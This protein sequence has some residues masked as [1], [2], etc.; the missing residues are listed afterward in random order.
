MKYFGLFCI[1]T[2][3]TLGYTQPPDTLWTRTYGGTGNDVG[4]SIKQT[5]D[6][7]YIIAGYTESFGAGQQD[8]WLLKTDGSGNTVWTKTYGGAYDDWAT[9]VQQTIDGGYVIAATTASFPY[10]VGG[11]M[12][13]MKTDPQGDTIWTEIYNWCDQAW[14][15]QQTSDS[16]YIVSGRRGFYAWDDGYVVI[17]KTDANGDTSWCKFYFR[18]AMA[19]TGSCVHETFDGNFVATAAMYTWNGTGFSFL[20]KTNS[21]GDSLWCNEYW[22]PMGYGYTSCL[23]S[24]TQTADSGY[25]TCGAKG[26][27]TLGLWIVR[28]TAQGDSIW[29]REYE[30]SLSGRFGNSVQI[31]ND[32]CF[33]FTGGGGTWWFPFGD[34][35]LL[36]TD[37]NGDSL[38]C[39]QYGGAGDDIGNEVRQTDDGGYIIVG[40]TGSYGAGGSDV[41]IIKTESDVGVEENEPFP[42]ADMEIS[43]TIFHGSL[44][45]PKGKKCRVYDITGRVVEP[46]KVGPG[47]YFIDVDGVVTRKVV[48][49]R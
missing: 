11:A 37:E 8:V 3:A 40:S 21:N 4:N 46:N 6:G 25:I 47:I 20:L 38:W 41:W 17:M 10:T 12:W 7:G 30:D 34:L 45:L 1:I 28:T 23:F 48:K 16:G 32:D 22:H 5:S 27:D 35:F 33:I 14:S 19:A 49:I 15:V 39:T 26:G 31:T 18:G 24:I 29:M 13:L 9:Y 36:K 2:T 44:Q 42:V 43:A